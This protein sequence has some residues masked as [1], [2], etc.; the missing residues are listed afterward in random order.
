MSAMRAVLVVTTEDATAQAVADALK[1]SHRLAAAGICRDVQ[2]LSTAI[3]RSGASAAVVDLGKQPERMLSDLQPV[4]GRFAQTRFVVLAEDSRSDLMLR[5]MEVGARHYMPRGA[6]AGMLADVLHRLVPENEPELGEGGA[7]ITVLSAG[8]GCGA[9][10]VAV[11]LAY[12]LHQ[13]G[14]SPALLVDADGS[15][16][17]AATY[18][19][20]SGAYG[21]TDVLSYSGIIDPH[22][23]AT[24]ARTDSRGLHVLLSPATVSPSE[25]AKMD[26]DRLPQVLD[27][28]KRGYKF[29]V[30]DA[31]RVSMDVAGTLARGSRLTYILCQLVVTDLRVARNMIDAM[32][33]RGADSSLIVPVITRY[34]KGKAM[35]GLD[36]ARKCLARESLLTISNDYA[37][38]ARAINYGQPLAQGSPKALLR[39]DIRQLALQIA[40]QTR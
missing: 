27:A 9:T 8:G 4:V 38:A 17:S 28:C 16:G 1:P 12:E 6:V 7:A 14:H 25:P 37:S 23:I 34:R 13:A 20:V 19:G 5:A 22:L 10:T 39:Q 31:P 40:P 35:I 18:L 33:S 3:A 36:E 21:L 32:V 2:E 11:N 29:T 26:F 15:Y 30:F 24:T